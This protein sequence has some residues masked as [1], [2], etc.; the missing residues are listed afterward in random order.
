MQSGG[1]DL[2]SIAVADA[3]HAQMLA[4]R[5]RELDVCLEVVA[6]INS[7]VVQF[8]NAIVDREQVE[9]SIR[10]A[11]KL[12]D[13]S[14]PQPSGLIEIPI[15]Y[16][17]DG[18]PDLNAVCQQLDLTVDEFISLH[19]SHDY[20]VDMLGFTPGFAYVGGL[21]ERLNVPRLTPP[22]VQVPSGSV[23][24]A[25]GRTGIY[26]LQGPGGWPLIGHTTLA[27]FDATAANPFTL[28]PGSRVR[29]VA[30]SGA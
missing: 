3:R 26:A 9:R 6:G 7:V 28:G 18:G 16:G 13:N 29:F 4:T 8:D 10:T 27:L 24:I 22:R 5:L 30:V 15:V 17:G 1:D 14:P 23:G 25:G 19:T 2:V 11:L 21:Q 12:P 20:E